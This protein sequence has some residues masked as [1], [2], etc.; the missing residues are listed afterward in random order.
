MLNAAIRHDP[1]PGDASCL[2][3]SRTAAA[4]L[5]LERGVQLLC[6]LMLL[7]EL[8][9]KLLELRQLRLLQSR[10]HRGGWSGRYKRY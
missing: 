8:G 10:V 2:S 5:L 9:F 7:L 4:M 6:M 3:G 1:V